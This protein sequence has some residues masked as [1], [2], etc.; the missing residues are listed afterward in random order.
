M[1]TILNPFNIGPSLFSTN[2]YSYYFPQKFAILSLIF[3]VLLGVSLERFKGEKAINPDERKLSETSI[4]FTCIGVG[5]ILLFFFYVFYNASDLERDS[6]GS[7]YR[8]NYIKK[9]ESTS[10]IDSL[11]NKYGSDSTVVKKEERKKEGYNKNLGNVPIT[12]NF[13]KEIIKT[14]DKEIQ[15]KYADEIY[16]DILSRDKIYYEKN[17]EETLQ[18]LDTR[19]IDYYKIENFKERLENKNNVI[20]E[21][22]KNLQSIERSIPEDKNYKELNEINEYKKDEIER[23]QQY[24]EKLFGKYTS[25]SSK[26]TL[27]TSLKDEIRKLET[28]KSGLRNTSDDKKILDKEIKR[29]NRQKFLT[30]QN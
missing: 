16:K 15:T 6:I 20:E 1:A 7:R 13:R 10:K 3:I 2:I 25:G 14:S 11:S 19:K 30:A 9:F 5:L 4:V 8:E 26:D 22:L 24:I 29:R 17:K 18:G 12:D 23:D 27:D 28:I 21:N